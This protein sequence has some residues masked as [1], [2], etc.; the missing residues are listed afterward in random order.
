VIVVTDGVAD[1]RLTVG[2][3]GVDTIE[4]RANVPLGSLA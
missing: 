1:V 4:L 3:V 2:G